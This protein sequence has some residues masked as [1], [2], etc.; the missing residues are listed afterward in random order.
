MILEM[1]RNFIRIIISLFIAVWAGPVT[2]SAETHMVRDQAGRMVAVPENPQRVIALAPSITEIVFELNQ[3]HRLKGVTIYSDYPEAATALPKVGSYVRLDLERIVALDPDLCLAVKDGNPKD[4]V[5]RLEALKIPVYVVNP[6]SLSTVMDTLLEVGTLLNAATEAE[7]VVQDMQTRIER[8][9]EKVE[10][11]ERN[12][13]VFFQIG[14]AP[15]VSVGSDTLI[16]EIIAAAGGKNLAAGPIPYPRFSR[17][18]VLALSPDIIVVTSMERQAVFDKVKSEWEEWQDLPAV[19]NHQIHIV[20]SDL[21]DRPS[22]R[23]VEALE[24]LVKLIHPDIMGN[25][26]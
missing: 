11:A 15:I 23:L 22:P 12:P 6:R 7:A 2:V 9:R 21:F 18:Q 26:Q 3:G 16:H 14:V 1:Q 19:R 5:T 13:R 10:K 8:V 24:M 4:V 20:D 17:E 25:P